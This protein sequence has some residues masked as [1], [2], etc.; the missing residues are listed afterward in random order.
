[1][2]LKSTLTFFTIIM[3]T[4]LLMNNSNGPGEEQDADRTGSPLSSG[5]CNVAGCHDDGVFNPSVSIELLKDNLPVDKYQPGETYD[6][7]VTITASQGTPSGYG[8]Q[9]VA[10][11]SNDESAGAWS[12]IPAGMHSITL[13]NNRTY[14]E[15]TTP[16][17]NN[18]TFE[19]KWTAPQA[20]TGEVT[21]YT[22]GNAVNLDNDVTG[23]GAKTA[24]ITF[25]EED[26][27]SIKTEHQFFNFTIFPNPVQ[28]VLNIEIGSRN[29]GEFDL[30]ITDI[31]GKIVDMER[32]Q[33]NEGQNEK[34]FNVNNLP[35]GFYLIHLR[36]DEEFVAQKML[37][38]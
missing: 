5:A 15:H 8:F 13:S 6:M 18:N 7:K 4:F 9:A 30:Q 33:L 2:N 3:A 36:H 37:K 38:I 34:K 25:T 29:S 35:I 28:D 11:S 12:D 27:N 22:A 17:T 31:N 14:V 16:N 24:Q 26:P 32:I 19:C 23:D 20:G 10:L 1:M 21:F